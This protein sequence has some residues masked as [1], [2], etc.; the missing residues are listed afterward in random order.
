MIALRKE[1]MKKKLLLSGT[2][3]VLLASFIAG[4]KQHSINTLVSDNVEALTFDDDEWTK[5]MF[6][7]LEQHTLYEY[8]SQYTGYYDIGS[9]YAAQSN[10]YV[11]HPKCTESM[12]KKCASK[13]IVDL[14][15]P[16][17]VHCYTITKE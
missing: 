6:G 14:S 11:I 7:T 17:S 4:Q 10:E 3:V 12:A 2:C 9:D 13:Q 1:T 5:N 15:S 16:R 8:P